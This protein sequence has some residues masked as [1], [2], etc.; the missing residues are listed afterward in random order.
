MTNRILYVMDDFPVSQN[1]VYRDADKAIKCPRGN[2][3]LEQHRITGILH[4]SSFRP[5]SVVYD[6][7]Y[8]N[9]QGHSAAFRDHLDQVVEIIGRHFRDKSILEIG[10]G[11][12]TFLELLRSRGFLATGVD[13]AYE[14]TSRYVLKEH[15]SN[16]TKFAGDAIILRHVLEHIPDP[17]DFLISIREINGGKGLVYIETPSFDWICQHRAWFDIY[18][19]H[20]NYFRLSDFFRFFETVV[21]SGTLFGGQYLYLIADLA[22]LSERSLRAIEEFEMPRDFLAG[23]DRTRSHSRKIGDRKIAIWGGSSK[24]VIFAFIFSRLCEVMPDFVIDI[25]PAKQ[26][27]YLPVTALPVLSPEDGLAQM[28][29]GDLILVMNSNYFEEIKAMAGENFV[30]H[31]VDQL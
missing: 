4:N 13:P 20:V 16:S 15:F 25:N 7:S 12:G 10:C 6:E 29:D 17:I 30:Y 21:E 5:G 23:I 11:K 8:Q 24:G 18:Y 26:G 2:I 14:G 31:R 19:E 22:M 9:E 1:V 27:K 28:K 3:K